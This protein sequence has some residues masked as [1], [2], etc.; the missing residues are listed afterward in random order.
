MVDRRG[1]YGLDGHYPRTGML[2]QAGLVAGLAAA[3]VGAARHRRPL[4]AAAAG[5]A[6]AGLGEV[7]AGYLYTTRRGKF[8]VWSELLDQLGL[9]GDEQILDV[10]CGRGAVLLLAAARVPR[11]R[12]VG[13]DLWLARDQ[14]GNSRASAERNAWREGVAGQVELVHADARDLPFDDGTFDVVISNLALHNIAG[15]QGRD[16][17]VREAVRVLRPGGQLRIVDFRADR[18]AEPLRAAGCEQLATRRP[19]WRM[20][21][22]TP[23]NGVTQISA[24]K[25]AQS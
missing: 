19:G 13:A 18:Y 1:H 4:L 14:S 11:G 6:A 22:G 21:F 8:E 25:P 24:L 2:V 23:I 17:A 3:A 5:V 9:T 7:T 16:A 10:G 12:A 20:S 15:D